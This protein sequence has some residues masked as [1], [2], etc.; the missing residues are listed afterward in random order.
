M[1]Q[2]IVD[3]LGKYAWLLD[4]PSPKML[5]E[6][7]ALYGVKETIGEADNPTILGWAKEL[8]LPAYN[9]DEIP[10]CGLF[11]AI[12]AKRAGKK[13]PENPLWARNWSKWGTTCSPAL[14]CV[15]VFSRGETSGHVGIYV[16][17]DKDCYHVLGGNQGDAVSIARIRK[18]RLIAARDSYNVRPDNVRPVF[19]SSIGSISK[20]EA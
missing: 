18:G 17:E 5:T 4:E 2:Y 10:W 11:C 6:A 3:K 12:V 1:I 14:G 16:G 20:N 19:L 9:H 15:L 8:G 7:L 13:I